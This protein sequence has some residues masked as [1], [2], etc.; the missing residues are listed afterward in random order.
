MNI[1]EQN[2]E[3]QIGYL[4]S[5]WKNNQ[6]QKTN[7]PKQGLG[8]KVMSILNS[9]VFSGFFREKPLFSTVIYF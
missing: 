9:T 7:Q 2:L 1:F 4:N 6:I 5:S 8:S 3:K